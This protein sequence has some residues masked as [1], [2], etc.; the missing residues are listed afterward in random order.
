[1]R[2]DAEALV[3]GPL[4]KMLGI[5]VRSFDQELFFCFSR[6]CQ[7]HY[8]KN[9][10]SRPRVRRRRGPQ[11]SRISGRLSVEAGDDS[12]MSSFGDSEDD[13]I[14]SLEVG[15]FETEQLITAV[16]KI[17][18]LLRKCWGVAG[19]DIISTNLATQ[20]GALTEVFN[21]T[22][23]GRSVYALFGFAAIG[24]FGHAVRNLGGDMYVKNPKGSVCL[25]SHLCLRWQHAFNQRHRS[26]ASWGSCA[27]G[28]W[29]IWWRMQQK[30]GWCFS[31]G[32]QN[33]PC[34]RCD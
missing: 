21:P 33:R 11:R 5:V 27:L 24:G 2:N 18:D 19:A 9:P 17:T 14:P 23:P 1:M 10:L 15:S 31:H 25:T 20:E 12:D 3:L 30:L 34:E 8:S 26:G 4:R 22:V 6:I 16:A 29:R 13:D 7:A 28:L 32:I